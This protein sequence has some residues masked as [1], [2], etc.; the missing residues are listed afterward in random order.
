[1]RFFSLCVLWVQASLLAIETDYD[2]AVVGTSP[3]S[4]LEAVYHIGCHEKVLVIESDERCGGAWKSIDMCGI[5]HVDLGC[6]MIGSDLRLQ[7]FLETYF[8]CHFVCLEHPTQKADSQHA[9]CPYGFYFSSGCG[10]FISH[11]ERR[12]ASQSHLL[13]RELKSIYIDV[14]RDFVTLNLGDIHYTTK[15]L[16]VTPSAHFEVENLGFRN[17]PPKIHSYFHLYFLIEDPSPFPFT[18]LYAGISGVSRV[19]NLTPFVQMPRQNLQLI[20][21]QVTRERELNESAKFFAAFKTKGWI[22]PQAELLKTETTIYTQFSSDVHQIK[23]IAG[24]LIEVLD[25]SSFLVMLKYIDKW[26]SVLQER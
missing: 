8:D 6:H 19:M 26:K 4:M 17:N 22:S 16:I 23:K 15:K 10:E 20:V 13:H 5:P 14:E 3:V 2:V 21:V 7:E 1:M 9:R 18:Y 25:S 11:L 24:S 12:V